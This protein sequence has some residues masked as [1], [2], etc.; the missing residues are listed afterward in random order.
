MKNIFPNK[1]SVLDKLFIKEEKSVY[2]RIVCK[3]F[4]C[5]GYN[6]S[7]FELLTV[8]DFKESKE[9]MEQCP[10]TCALYGYIKENT[11]VPKKRNISEE[12][13]E[14]LRETIKKAREARLNKKN[15]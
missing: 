12:H 4:D 10:A 7:M 3:C 15:I 5:C 11:Y 13:R 8:A 14:K 2:E 1:K 9:S 6:P